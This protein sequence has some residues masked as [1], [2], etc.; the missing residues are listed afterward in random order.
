MK[1]R[2][3]A[4]AAVAAMILTAG[5]AMTSFAKVRSVGRSGSCRMETFTR[6]TTAKNISTIPT[7]LHEKPI[8]LVRK[9]NSSNA[10]STG[11]IFSSSIV[12]AC[13]IF[14]PTYKIFV[15]VMR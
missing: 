2:Y 12:G 8:F 9:K 1:K 15:V 7:R 5:M 6:S 10:S 14:Q 13:R 4:G 11:R 3:F